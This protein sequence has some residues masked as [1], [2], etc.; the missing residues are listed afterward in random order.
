MGGF[1]P[2]CRGVVMQA[3]KVVGFNQRIPLMVL[4]E[5]IYR[6]VKDKEIDREQITRHLGEFIKGQNR[7]KKGAVYTWQIL[8]RQKQYLEW[9]RQ[10]IDADAYLKVPIQDRHALSLCL[11]CLTYPVAY[12]LLVCISSALKTQ[13][14]ISKQYIREKMT[15]QYGSNRSIYNAIEAVMLMSMEMG[16]LKR[17]KVGIYSLAQKLKITNPSVKEL[18]VF[19]D[20]KLSGSRS[21]LYEDIGFRAWY[22]YFEFELFKTQKFTLFKYAESPIGQGYLRI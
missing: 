7:L 18:I 14:Q 10:T 11:L 19:T 17:D 6:F 9:L 4:D 21:M 12:D 5:A 13:S 20:I 2:L 3:H 16:I 15:A 22:V 8:S 1:N